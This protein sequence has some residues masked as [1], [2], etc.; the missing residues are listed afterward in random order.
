MR[1]SK[2]LR[3]TDTPSQ[4]ANAVSLTDSEQM[5]FSCVISFDV[6]APLA[7]RTFVFPSCSSETERSNER[8][9]REGR[10]KTGRTNRRQDERQGGR[11]VLFPCLNVD[12][13]KRVQLV[14]EGAAHFLEIHVS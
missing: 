4:L 8:G 2:V 7:T 13:I 12:L 11:A 14:D 1:K 6:V 3:V 10:P 5:N 9:A